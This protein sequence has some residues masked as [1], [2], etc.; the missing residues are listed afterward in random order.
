MVQDNGT[1]LI[2]TPIC[3]MLGRAT[4]GPMTNGFMEYKLNMSQKFELVQSV[5]KHF[6]DRWAVEVTPD[7]LIC[8]KWHKTGRNL[9]MGDNILVHFKTPLKGNIC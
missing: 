9:N 4:N 7:W 3:L 1:Y 2:L 8:K 5:T 6:W